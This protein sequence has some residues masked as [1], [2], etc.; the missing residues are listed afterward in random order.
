M[1]LKNQIKFSYLDSNIINKLVNQ[2]LKKGN[3]YKSY[4]II[5]KVFEYIK[6][7]NVNINPILLITVALN[8]VKPFIEVKSYKKRNV[9]LRVPSKISK[10]R[11]ETLAIKWIIQGA[12]ARKNKIFAINL[13]EELIDAYN[14][15]GNAIKLKLEMHK[16]ALLHKRFIFSKK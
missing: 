6:N 11:Q 16:L 2:L 7:S 8:N 14:Y 3:K 12:K 13:A 1:E 10:N 5:N 9:S 15:K 4:L